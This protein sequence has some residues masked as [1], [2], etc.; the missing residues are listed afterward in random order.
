VPERLPPNWVS[1]PGLS[2]ARPKTASR[3]KTSDAPSDCRPEPRSKSN[4]EASVRASP[5]IWEP[6]ATAVLPWPAIAPESVP[7]S[8]SSPASGPDAPTIANVAASTRSTSRPP[9]VTK[10]PP[11]VVPARVSVAGTGP[12]TPAE[13]GARKLNTTAV[14]AENV[15][16]AFT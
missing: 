10:M 9:G 11:V 16:S 12:T 3:P 8:R 14:L 5:A 1:G 13:F 6:P 7:E 2:P 4:A 15:P